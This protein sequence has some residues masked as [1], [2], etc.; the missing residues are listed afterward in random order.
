M[1]KAIELVELNAELKV[2][3]ITCDGASPNRR[4]F[5]MHK[6]E[7]QGDELVYRIE[8]IYALDEGR[9]LYFIC[10]VPHLLKT[11][12]NCFANSYSMKKRRKLWRCGKSI[13]RMHV[14]DLYKKHVQ[15]VLYSVCPK[16]TKAHAD[17]SSLSCMKVNLAPQ[18]LS[19]TVVNA[20]QHHYGAHASE[21]V[22]FI[23]IVNTFFDVMNTRNLYEA[24]QTRNPNVEPINRSDDPRLMWLENDFLNYYNEWRESVENRPGDF[25]VRKKNAMQ[26][27]HQ[28]LTG[29]SISVASIV[30]CT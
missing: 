21:T 11:T 20:L 17:L 27:S 22:K 24:K 8:N 9:Y 3:F 6:S 5:E 10:D 23:K 4:S 12:R 30:G 29:L 2:M 1:S 26:I 7:A 15:D 16:L 14:V 25:T 18:V 19:E 13:S 28:T